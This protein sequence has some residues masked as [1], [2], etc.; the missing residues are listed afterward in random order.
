MAE[1]VKGLGYSSGHVFRK[2]GGGEKD[3][4]VDIACSLQRM[5]QDLVLP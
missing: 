5:C 4:V 1:T 3:K 2:S